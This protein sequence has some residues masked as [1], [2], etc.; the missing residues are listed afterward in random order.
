MLLASILLTA[1]IVFFSSYVKQKNIEKY[2]QDIITL[3][4]DFDEA[5]KD[6]SK[7]Q[8][9]IVN[10]RTPVSNFEIEMLLS[11]YREM[12]AT[13]STYK[14]DISIANVISIRIT[15]LLILSR[16]NTTI[17]IEEEINSQ[18]ESFKVCQK[19]ISYNSQKATIVEKRLRKCTPYINQAIDYSTALPSYL[20]SSF[21]HDEEMPQNIIEKLASS[22]SILID[23]YVFLGKKNGVEATRTDKLYQ[24]SLLKIKNTPKWNTCVTKYLQIQTDLLSSTKDT[25][26]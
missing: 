6:F 20:F 4:N 16:I 22:H 5:E 18:M 10:K 8:A 13:L 3:T 14:S 26:K 15:D 12:N 24:N 1:L 9:Q 7:I 19:E 23:Y 17:R 11:T 25:R 21:C 2:K